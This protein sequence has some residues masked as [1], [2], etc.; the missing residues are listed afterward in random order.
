MA[1]YAI[2]DSC[3][4]LYDKADFKGDVFKACLD[5]KSYGYQLFDLSKEKFDNKTESW[6]CGRDVRYQ[7]CNN[8]TELGCESVDGQSG[9]GAAQ[10]SLIID[11][12]MISVVKLWAY[13]YEE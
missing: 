13:D 6:Q 5:A 7:F 8:S 2:P 11:K 4:Y 10:N 9:G 3:C 1:S 12:N